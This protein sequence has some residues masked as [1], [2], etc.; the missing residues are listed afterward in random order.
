MIKEYTQ[1]TCKEKWHI[2][3]LLQEDYGNNDIALRLGRSKSTISREIRR[4]K[5]SKNNYSADRACKL[6]SER[7]KRMLPDKFTARAK[8]IIRVKLEI[9]DSPEQISAHLKKEN[10]FISHELIYQYIDKNRKVGG[11]LYKLLPRRGNK[12]KKRNVK[13]NRRVWQ[14]A[15]KRNPISERPA[16]ASEKIEVG[17]WEG[18]TVESK[19]HKG[20]IGTF[21]DI[22]SKFVIIRKL[23]NKSSFAMKNAIIN[24]FNKS[25]EIIKTITLDNGTEFALHDE[26]SR[27]LNTSIYF[28][29]PYSPWE[30]GLNENTN[31]L[32]R[33]F[34]PKG[35]DF[36]DVSDTEILRV[37][38]LLN[39]RPRKTL[40]F[41]TPKEVLTKELFN[42]KEY[43]Q[44]V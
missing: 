16:I 2:E 38:N 39:E 32:I 6:A 18:D 27:E 12:Y 35:T 9:G 20:G 24:A 28:A 26:I 41:K 11:V 34:Y 7:C 36:S 3:L 8:S 21:V 14:T 15:K 29:N 13:N 22:K 19:G 37:Q 44:I 42:R 5:D 10:T 1:L 30:R 17:H 31:G 23:N 33:R 43:L 4:N 40:G 25:P